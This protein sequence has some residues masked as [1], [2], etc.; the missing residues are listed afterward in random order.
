MKNILFFLL[1]VGSSSA[2][3]GLFRRGVT[4]LNGVPTLDGIPLSQ[5]PPKPSVRLAT[6]GAIAQ[7]GWTATCDSQVTGNECAKA[8]DGDANT[9]WLTAAT[10]ALPH[11][12]TIDTK[13]LQLIGSVTIQ[14]RQDGNNDGHIGQH[15]IA[16]RY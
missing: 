15:T 2:G 11:S 10:A 6:A 9:F 4:V 16:L 14:P 5:I 8:I 12:I 1:L 7:S 13:T 3:N